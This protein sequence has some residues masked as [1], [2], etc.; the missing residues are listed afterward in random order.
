MKIE[1]IIKNTFEKDIEQYRS[2]IPLFSED[3][4]ILPGKEK[5]RKEWY[6]S[7]IVTTIMVLLVS[8]F[9]LR[10]G[11]FKSSLVI[12][13]ADIVKLIPENPTEAFL[14]FLQMINSSM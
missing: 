14:G 7:L 13:W 6:G 1:E 10:T 11:M 12:P 9:S 3:V 5:R 2:G 4:Y 8:M